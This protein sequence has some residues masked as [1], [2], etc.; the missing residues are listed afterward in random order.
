[1]DLGD[2]REARVLELLFSRDPGAE[3][4]LAHLGVPS[5]EADATRAWLARVSREARASP[6]IS[7]EREEAL[8]RRILERTTRED[9]GLRGEVR[10]LGAF[11]RDRLASSALLRLVA[12]SLLLEL[13]ALPVVA[14]LLRSGEPEQPRLVFEIPREAPD[15][16]FAPEPEESLAP[17]LR[18]PSEGP[19]QDAL[20][21]AARRARFVLTTRRG[22]LFEGGPELAT[23]LLAARARFLARGSFESWLEEAPLAEVP[24]DLERVLWIEVLLDR[25]QLTGERARALEALVP[26]LVSA[27]ERGDAVS[28]LARGA[29]DRL[30]ACGIQAPPAG[31]DPERLEAPLGSEWFDLLGAAFAARG[32]APPALDRWME[33]RP[34]ERG[35]GR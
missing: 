15:E 5:G 1:M 14:F 17:D 4:E 11:L 16:P 7:P 24:G 23:R 31:F 28:A 35:A 18:D 2:E 3:S 19:A 12:A 25:F 33:W 10:L 6:W 22:P 29:I 26:P 34:M 9:L 20:E 32:E 21:N 27:R 13:F 8:V 30:F